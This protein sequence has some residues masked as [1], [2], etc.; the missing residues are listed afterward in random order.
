MN[1]YELN[2]A[3]QAIG[4]NLIAG[5][6]LFLTFLSAYAVRRAHAAIASAAPCAVEFWI[7]TE[8]V[9]SCFKRKSRVTTTATDP[10]N[11]AIAPKAS[12]FISHPKLF[13]FR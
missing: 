3:I 10:N 1:E 6:A 7:I 13:N 5:E 9:L 4:S 8:L 2:D 11:S 12:Q